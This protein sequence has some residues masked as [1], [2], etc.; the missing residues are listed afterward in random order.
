MAMDPDRIRPVV[1]LLPP[2][3]FTGAQKG[4]SSSRARAST[5]RVVLLPARSSHPATGVSLSGPAAKTLREVGG[6]HAPFLLLPLADHYAANGA[7]TLPRRGCL[8]GHRNS[9]LARVHPL[10]HAIGKFALDG[11]VPGVPAQVSQFERIV[12]QIEEL[13]REAVE[14]DQ[15]PTVGAHLAHARRKFHELWTNHKSA[16][17]K[18]A[19][20]LFGRLYEVDVEWPTCCQTSACESGN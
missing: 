5:V 8:V 10:E 4:C 11:L 17:A 12:F 1:Y 13:R 7:W 2:A 15:L 3:P 9:I 19:L 20:V 16:L 6:L 18:Q 14:M